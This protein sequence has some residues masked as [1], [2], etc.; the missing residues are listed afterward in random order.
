MV[1]GWWAR[2]TQ[3]ERRRVVE[4]AGTLALAGVIVWQYGALA[5][6]II[7]VLSYWLSMVVVLIQL[8]FLAGFYG[9]R[10]IRPVL[11]VTL[12]A[13]PF[14]IAWGYDAAYGKDL[15]LIWYGEWLAGLRPAAAALVIAA[16][17]G[18]SFLAGLMSRKMRNS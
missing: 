17:A 15:F 2:A 9:L 7:I 3:K 4:L 8:P 18:A 16:L 11:V 6:R 1:R 10:R 14:A 13:L 5:P 12:V